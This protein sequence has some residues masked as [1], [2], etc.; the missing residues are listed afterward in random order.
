MKN[1]LLGIVKK[2]L[3]KERETLLK[4]ITSAKR[5]R[6]SAPSAIE[7]HHDTERNQSEKMVVALE[8]KLLELDELIRNLPQN[9]TTNNVSNGVWGYY[10]IDKDGNNLKIILVPDGYGGREAEGIKLVSINTPIAR[11]ILET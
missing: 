11:S 9:I 4:A 3:E 2:C 8:E 6:D 7:S 5:A 10:E 1:D